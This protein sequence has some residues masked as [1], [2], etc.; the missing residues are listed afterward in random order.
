MS[1]DQYMSGGFGPFTF[2]TMFK[3]STGRMKFRVSVRNN[4]IIV[5][6]PGTQL[7]GY[8]CDVIPPY[9]LEPEIVKRKKRFIKV[10]S[11]EAVDKSDL[12]NIKYS[13]K[14][15][16]WSSLKNKDTQ[17]RNFDSDV[18]Y[19]VENVHSI[20]PSSTVTSANSVGREKYGNESMNL[21]SHKSKTE[22]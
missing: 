11:F 17:P 20:L 5:T 6:L 12:T 14:F 22:Y 21:M 15:S 16:R 13:N 19:S 4:N 1:Y 2:G 9:P 3:A 7:I 8:M 18:S 10:D